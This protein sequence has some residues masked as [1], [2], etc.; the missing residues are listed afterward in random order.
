M[1]KVALLI[2]DMQKNCKEETSCKASFDKAVEYINEISQYFRN[3]KHPVVIIQDIEA[4]GPETDGFKCVDELIVS[5]RDI[6][7][8][9]SFSNAFW[10]TDLD[11]ILKNEGVDCVVISGFAA[12][13]CALFTYN[14]A[15]ERGY[16]TFLMQNGIAGFSDDEIKNIQLLRSVVSYDALEYFLKENLDTPELESIR[17]MW[18]NYLESIG[19]N[20]SSTNKKY[21]AWHFCDNEQDAN[22]L[23]ELVLQ[24]TKR[25]TASLYLSYNN[26]EELPKVGDLSII[27]NWDGV[28]QC[29]IKTTNIDIVPYKNVTEEFAATEGEG[30]KSLDYWRR[31][32]WSYF[33]REMK[34]IGKEPTDDM[35]VL[36]EKFEV[37]FK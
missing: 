24:G 19:E 21:T 37:V 18:D 28:A 36:C 14:G 17:Q 22:E 29:I 15:R 34:E 1:S 32:H 7:I 8:Q 20:T 16:N 27:I 30:D 10:E 25:A 26:E 9:K 2:I 31:A 11:A 3:K 13:H 6:F 5:D 12:E 35:L 23:A 33:S 4:G